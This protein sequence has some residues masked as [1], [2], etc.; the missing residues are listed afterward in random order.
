MYKV[1]K[2]LKLIVINEND[3]KNLIFKLNKMSKYKI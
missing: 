3:K 1:N 2:D